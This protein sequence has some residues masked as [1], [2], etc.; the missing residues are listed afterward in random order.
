MGRARKTFPYK[1]DAGNLNVLGYLLGKT[2]VQF[3]SS[4]PSRS[5]PMMSP[6]QGEQRGGVAGEASP[7][8][9]THFTFTLLH[10]FRLSP[11]ILF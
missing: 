6:E 4:S 7:P 8:T 11:V 5:P 3:A 1:A 2:E 10:D 9:L